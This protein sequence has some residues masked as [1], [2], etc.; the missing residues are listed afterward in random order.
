MHGDVDVGGGAEIEVVEHRRP[1]VN[2]QVELDIGH[3]HGV[4][5]AEENG[6]TS[7]V[8]DHRRDDAPFFFLAERGMLEDGGDAQQVGFHLLEGGVVEGRALARR[9]SLLRGQ[10][11]GV[12]HHRVDH[13]ADERVLPARLVDALAHHEPLVRGAG[14]DV[15][16][17][18]AE[19]DALARQAVAAPLAEQVAVRAER[20]AKQHVAAG[21]AVGDPVGELAEQLRVRVTSVDAFA[22]LGA[23][24]VGGVAQLGRI[25][26]VAHVARPQGTAADD[27]QQAGEGGVVVEG[28]VGDVGVQL[29]CQLLY[30]IH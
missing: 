12:G 11:G 3:E 23:D 15:F 19:T 16:R 17:A 9:Q 30:F 10:M 1:T 20:G 4:P 26:H 28:P 2:A 25:V 21:D 14:E 5:L 22:H 18:E 27:A 13:L 24:Q 7:L 6:R 8:G 29:S